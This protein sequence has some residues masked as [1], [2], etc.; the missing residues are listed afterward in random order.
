MRRLDSNVQVVFPVRALYQSHGILWLNFSVLTFLE[1][2]CYGVFF[3]LKEDW[4]G[5]RH[6]Q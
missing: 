5:K 2:A 3:R 1:A 6:F 4:E